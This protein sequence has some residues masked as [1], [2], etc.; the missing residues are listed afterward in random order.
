METSRDVI[1]ALPRELVL[2]VASFRGV[3][4]RMSALSRRLRSVVHP[5]V[6][7]CAYRKPITGRELVS[8]IRDRCESYTEREIGIDITS[9]V[10]G[11][12]R[13]GDGT[14]L[15]G[16]VTISLL[17][18]GGGVVGAPHADDTVLNGRGQR[19]QVSASRCNYTLPSGET[20]AAPK[21][22]SEFSGWLAALIGYLQPA[23]DL[24]LAILQLRVRGVP[25]GHV[26]LRYAHGQYV[27]LFGRALKHAATLAGVDTKAVMGHVLDEGLLCRVR[28]ATT[29]AALGITVTVRNAPLLQAVM[30]VASGLA[31]ATGREVVPYASHS[32]ALAATHRLCTFEYADRSPYS[33]P[34]TVRELREFLPTLIAS[35]HHGRDAVEL[36]FC[37]LTSRHVRFWVLR[38]NHEAV[39]VSR[40]AHGDQQRLENCPRWRE[41][42]TVPLSTLKD[43]RE[44]VVDL[45]TWL[46]MRGSSGEYGTVVRDQ[47]ERTCVGLTSVEDLLGYETDTPDTKEWH[48]RMQQR[49]REARARGV[50]LSKGVSR[51]LRIAGMALRPAHGSASAAA[52]LEACRELGKTSFMI[53]TIRIDAERVQSS[54]LRRVIQVLGGN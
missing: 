30:D 27:R 18:G 25:D 50:D 17:Q 10:L 6:H 35:V 19:L 3:A 4:C 11:G 22:W 24:G 43:D 49:I 37:P 20:Y 8:Y 47:L 29:E 1:A 36:M 54:A 44:L 46:R 52:G 21:R 42:V 26:R 48:D 33:G 7:A 16:A 51:L 9:V 34:V 31:I 39:L 15:Q 23:R 5:E 40:S 41:E 32:S 14:L 28:S 12:V 45:S 13:G 38:A 53:S 2:Y